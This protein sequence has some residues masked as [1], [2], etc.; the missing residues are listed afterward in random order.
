MPADSQ[1]VPPLPSGVMLQRNLIYFK[2]GRAL[3][4]VLSIF[5]GSFFFIEN[6]TWYRNLFYFAVIPVC[7]ACLVFSYKSMVWRNGVLLAAQGYI[8]ILFIIF[9]ANA[10]D[11]GRLLR[12]HGARYVCIAVYL[13]AFAMVGHHCRQFSG[14]AARVLAVAGAAAALVLMAQDTDLARHGFRLDGLG[15]A[16]NPVGTG[17]AFAL[18]AVAAGCWLRQGRRRPWQALPAAAALAIL[19]AAVFLSETRA[20]M[21]GA[22]AGLLVAFSASLRWVLA[23]AAGLAAVLIGVILLG[24]VDWTDLI[25]RAD[26][27]RFEIWSSYL[28]RLQGH[29]LFGSGAYGEA[30]T[31]VIQGHIEIAYPHNLL[32]SAAY[33]GGAAALAAVAVTLVLAVRAAGRFRAASGDPMP[34]AILAIPLVCGLFDLNHLFAEAGWEWQFGW[35]PVGLAIAARASLLNPAAGRP[36]TAGSTG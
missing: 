25:A 32:L 8:F 30:A 3:L 31:I 1:P 12:T 34:L 28:A 16:P 5:I 24:L 26:N 27:G 17:I 35:L 7:A 18:A 2:D 23:G 6:V 4:A 19:L 9:A 20:A 22:A 15:L 36:D 14:V 11:D 21:L 33:A 29:W 10:L 13:L